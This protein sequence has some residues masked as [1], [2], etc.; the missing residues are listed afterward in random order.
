[1]SRPVRFA[2]PFE[3]H[4]HVSDRTDGEGAQAVHAF[5]D[6]FENISPRFVPRI[7]SHMVALI[8]FN[9][10]L[11]LCS[12]A[13]TRERKIHHDSLDPVVRTRWIVMLG[14]VVMAALYV[15]GAVGDRVYKMDSLKYN[16]QHFA[17]VFWLGEYA[18]A[19]K[20]GI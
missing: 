2:R 14:I 18:K 6:R 4:G 9:V 19:L 5:F 16:R 7:P 12:D 15:A 8:T 17:N 3:S 1:M 20:Q 11:I 10:I 13:I